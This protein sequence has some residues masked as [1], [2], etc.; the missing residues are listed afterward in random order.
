[1]SQN[2]YPTRWIK[3]A[4]DQ[5]IGKEVAPSTWRKWLRLFNVP[6]WERSL[7]TDQA[8]LI[9]TYA[10]LRKSKP[11]EQIGII[12]VKHR[13]REV[14][15]NAETLQEQI[16]QGLFINAKGK[17]LPRLIRQYTGKQV[18]LRTLYRWADKHK[19]EF[20][21][22]KRLGRPEIKKWLELAS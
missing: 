19:L 12:A 20:G 17:D 5:I 18:T 13:L 4:A 2:K 14:P 6:A 11:N 21:A 10:H 3:L 15:L 8:I 7:T 9:C 1:M 22:S 16:E